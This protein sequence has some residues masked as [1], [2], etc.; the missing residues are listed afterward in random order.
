VTAPHHAPADLIA[1]RRW[2]LVSADPS[3][4]T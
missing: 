3:A 1:T 2:S 4:S